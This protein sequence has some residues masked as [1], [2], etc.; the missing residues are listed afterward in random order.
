MS[1]SLPYYLKN[2]LLKNTT[3]NVCFEELLDMNDDQF[4]DWVIHMRKSYKDTW[5]TT[6]S[7]PRTGASEQEIIQEFNRLENVNVKKFEFLDTDGR[8][9]I[10]KNT[11]RS[12]AQVDQ[13][14][15]NMM[16]VPMNYNS[17]TDGYSV[18]DLF[19][20]K[21]HELRMIKRSKRHFKKDSFYHYSWVVRKNNSD[22]RSLIA[23]NTI[24]EWLDEYFA[25]KDTK[26]KD[27]N[28]WISEVKKSKNK[29]TGYYQVSQTSLVYAEKD[30]M[31]KIL[32]DYEFEFRQI[33]NIDQNLKDNIVYVI[34]VYKYGQRIFPKGFAAF[35]IGYVSIPVNFPPMTAKYLYE[36]YTEHLKDSERI[37][38][39]DPSSGWGGR[40]LGCMSVKDDRNIHYVGTDPNPDNIHT[41]GKTKYEHIADFYN[42]K[43]NRK[44]LFSSRNTYDIYTVGSEEIDK[45]KTFRQ[46][47]GK[48]DLVFTSPPYFNRELYSKDS[49]QAAVKYGSSYDL[50]RDEYL[51]RTL[52]ICVE[53][54][55]PGG[56][57]LWNI[58]DVLV[59]TGYLPLEADS[60]SIL[61]S[62]GMKY[63]ETLKM[64]LQG[65]PGAQ[66]VDENG[67]PKCK[68]Y[69]KVG[70]QYFKYEPI[71]VFRK[72]S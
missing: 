8:P 13:W 9:N 64:T 22:N 29:S 59:E 12:G 39:Y 43:T 67:I 50:W 72:P 48:I 53:Y 45:E 33:S 71:F 68:N 5:D 41:D 35:R 23:A 4:K 3:V 7:P 37:V 18:Y 11:D 46:Y 2:N 63:E 21:E 31:S 52:E 15:T 26:Y 38:V 14:F 16:K 69:C 28:F 44:S 61:E 24:R 34:R 6:G 36:R 65:M 20:Q 40:I 10:I 57:L 66:R 42:T 55:K 54:L 70:S 47:K 60:R 19:S 30:E 58:A 27:Y 62:L 56:Y 1:N 49:K 17:S 51:K 32:K 25:H